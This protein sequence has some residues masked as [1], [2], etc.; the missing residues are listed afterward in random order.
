MDDDAE[1]EETSSKPNVAS[2]MSSDVKDGK[3]GSF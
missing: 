1:V 2:G 3:A